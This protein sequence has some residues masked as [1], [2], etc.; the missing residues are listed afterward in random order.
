MTPERADVFGKTVSGNNDIVD[1]EL[2]EIGKV[3]TLPDWVAT[4]NGCQLT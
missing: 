2:C 4:L 1:G 3:S